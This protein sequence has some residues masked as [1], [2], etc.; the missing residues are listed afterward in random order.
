[1]D[2]P[3]LPRLSGEIEFSRGPSWVAES[4]RRGPDARCL[5]PPGAQPLEDRHGPG[6]V[7]MQTQNH[8]SVGCASSRCDDM[9]DGFVL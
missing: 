7:D 5:E 1:M 9:A 3:S 6:I 4:V 2:E 8:R